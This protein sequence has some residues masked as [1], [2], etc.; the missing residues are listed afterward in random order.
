MAILSAKGNLLWVNRALSDFLGYQESELMHSSL[1]AVTHKDDLVTATAGL[2]SM[3]QRKSD[4]LQMEVRHQRR[5][6]EQ[7]WALWNVARFTDASDD[8][9][10]LILHLQKS[11]ERNRP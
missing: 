1:K 6:G 4:F 11:P 5:G 2:K 9:T 10:Y 8:G 7:V 3:L